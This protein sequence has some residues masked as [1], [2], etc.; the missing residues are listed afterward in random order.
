MENKSID[1][2]LS[3]IEKSRLERINKSRN[4]SSGNDAIIK[5]LEQRVR[6]DEEAELRKLQDGSDP[7]G[8]SEK[9]KHRH[10]HRHHHHY[11]HHHSSSKKSKRSKSK[12]A[13]VSR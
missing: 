6:E 3:Q 9:S 1:E 7:E 4:A 2:S 8:S 11:H 10:H 5:E 12:P 13:F